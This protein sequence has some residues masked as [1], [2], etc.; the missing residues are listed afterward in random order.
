MIFFIS[1]NNLTANYISLKVDPNKGMFQYE[2][3]FAPNI[4]SRPLRFKLLNQH[5]N[6]LGNVQTFDRALL[7]LPT[8]LANDVMFNLY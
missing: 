1:R 3:K 8:K 4:D 6:A 7:C 5:L 2:V